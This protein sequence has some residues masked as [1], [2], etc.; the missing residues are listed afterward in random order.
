V[1]AE[2]PPFNIRF[3]KLMHWA[4][5]TACKSRAVTKAKSVQFWAMLF[6]CRIE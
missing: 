5:G 2:E 3:G 6:A 4:I 1:T